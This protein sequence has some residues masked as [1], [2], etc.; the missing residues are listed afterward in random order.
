MSS[1]MLQF[2]TVLRKNLLLNYRTKATF[3]ELINIGIIFGVIIALT[4]SNG[5]NSK[6]VIPIY[7]SLAI[8]MFCRGVAM[9][10]V[11]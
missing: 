11:G 8:L 4:Y 3:R 10:W 6:Q 1:F 2:K 7:M 5:S 9:S